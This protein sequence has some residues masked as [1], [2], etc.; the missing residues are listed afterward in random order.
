MWGGVRRVSFLAAILVVVAGLGPAAEAGTASRLSEQ[1][2]IASAHP[3]P[4]SHSRRSFPTVEH[5][6]TQRSA[7]AAA[8]SA[9]PVQPQLTYGGGRDGIGVTLAP[10]VYVV[11]WGSQWGAANPPG[12]TNFSG[13]PLGVASRVVALLSGIGTNSE[14]WSGVMT[15][16]CEGVA[17]RLRLLCRRVPH[18]GYPDG[19]ALAGVWADTAAP[20]PGSA[21]AAQL[22]AEAVNAAQHF[23]NTTAASTTGT[24][25]TSSSHRR[26]PSP[27]AST[28]AAGSAR[29]TTSTADVGTSSPYGDI[30]F[31]NLPYVPDMH[32]SC[33]MNFV[34]AGTA[35]TLDGVTMVEGHEYAET[36]TDQNPGRRMAR[37]AGLEN[38]DK[39]AWLSS[40][41]GR[42]QNVSFATGTFAMQGTWSNADRSCEIAGSIWGRPGGPDDFA[43][44]ASPHS[45]FVQ[46]GGVANTTVLTARVSGNAQPL[47]LAVSGEPAGVTASLSNDSITSDD[48]V[49]LTVTTS[50]STP[51]GTYPLTITAQGS[52][53]HTAVYTRGRRAA[54]HAA[55]AVGRG[56]ES[57]RL[58]RL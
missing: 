13:D 51:F 53:T 46:P 4:R 11:F 40:G 14:E 24:R 22:G 17:D 56:H 50:N 1:T 54:A 41:V 35:G 33:G 45:A 32:S 31:T 43:L 39:C 42:S 48:S 3:P 25:S 8:P 19:G 36:I 47:Q 29:G 9:G 38:A 7:L 55:A 23:G 30:A 52:V 6:R 37:L 18:V 15:Q 12:S 57:V 27:T 2:T 28:P 58:G 26:V 20:A 5:A 49:S 16:Y 21:T 34:N 10:K 44:S